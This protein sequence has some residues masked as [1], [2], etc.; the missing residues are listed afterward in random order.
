[1]DF[2]ENQT[3]DS[4]Y[5]TQRRSGGDMYR[6]FWIGWMIGGVIKKQWKR[7]KVRRG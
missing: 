3:L 6:S 2:N 7:A 4:L 1:M 5:S